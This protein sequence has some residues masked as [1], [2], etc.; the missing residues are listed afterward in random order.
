MPSQA[1]S[2]RELIK[3]G[4][5]VEGYDATKPGRKSQ[6]YGVLDER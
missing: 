4:L 2:I 6:S 1:A 5:P 3:R